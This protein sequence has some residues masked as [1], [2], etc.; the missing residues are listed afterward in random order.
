[1]AHTT[2]RRPFQVGLD[3]SFEYGHAANLE[4]LAN[5]ESTLR[6]PIEI[7]S[8]FDTKEKRADPSKKDLTNVVKFHGSGR[9]THRAIL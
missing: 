4:E 3:E 5:M 6:D 2:E 1:M 9:Q 7:I 8:K